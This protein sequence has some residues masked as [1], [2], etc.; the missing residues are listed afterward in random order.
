MTEDDQARPDEPEEESAA[1]E[2]EVEESVRLLRGAA[3]NESE[4][5]CLSASRPTRLVVLAG[6]SAS[7]KTT[8]ISSI[9]ERFQKG[10]LSGLCFG[11]SL[12]LVGFEERCFL[13]RSSSGNASPDTP[14]TPRQ[15]GFQYLHL[16]VRPLAD[17]SSRRDLVFADVTGEMYMEA[18]DSAEACR[19]LTILG[20]ANCIWLLMDGAALAN[21]KTRQAC[22]QETRRL[23][24]R[25]LEEEMIGVDTALEL[26]YSKWDEVEA[27]HTEDLSLA[28][29]NFDEQLQ[30]TVAPQLLSLRIHRT[31]ASPKK[32]PNLGV[33]WGVES[34]IDAC[35]GRP[36]APNFDVA[37]P[38]AT[39]RDFLSFGNNL[40]VRG[41]Q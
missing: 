27:S 5:L 13:A 39:H 1:I 21:V 22:L 7:G 14:H 41:Q 2:P 40:N 31:A 23:L 28:I 34:L 33:G 3:L 6:S 8:L 25:L 10:P 29:Q 37:A 35:T 17:L 20:R 16:D 32:N 19:Q 9:Y 38:S 36:R 18:K 11:G 26:V 12:T 15:D 4:L 24:R 30:Q